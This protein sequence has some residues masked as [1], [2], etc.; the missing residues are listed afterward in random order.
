MGADR[1]DLFRNKDIVQRI[2]DANYR[3][4]RPPDK[5][6]VK[7]VAGDGFVKLSWDNKAEFSRDP[8]LGIDPDSMGFK[9]DFE[10]YV[11]YKSTDPGLLDSRLITDAFG[12]KIFRQ[13]E[14]PI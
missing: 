8:F 11:I 13:S 3:F 7:A 4:A 2:F 10:G 5:P 12:N 9:K 1:D 14:S 6:T